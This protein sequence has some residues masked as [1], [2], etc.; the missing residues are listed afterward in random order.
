MDLMPVQATS[1]PSEHIFS[2]SKWTTTARRNHLTPKIME[3]TQILNL[4]LEAKN[5]REISFTKGFSLQEEFDDL[6]ELE[7]MATAQDLRA[8]LSG[9]CEGGHQEGL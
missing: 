9:I 4:K 8:Y 5:K 2:A 6:E 1:V 3:A 7:G